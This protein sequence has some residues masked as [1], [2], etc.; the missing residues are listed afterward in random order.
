VN[1][2]LSSWFFLRSY[3][4]IAAGILIIAL[5]LDSLLLWMLPT[6]EQTSVQRY[7]A[8]FAL[9]ELLLT[10]PGADPGASPAR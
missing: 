1:S 3:I 9:I 6:S 7:A 8:D 10:E 4:V 2:R 5:A